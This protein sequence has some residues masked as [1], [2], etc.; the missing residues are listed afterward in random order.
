MNELAAFLR[1]PILPPKWRTTCGRSSLSRAWARREEGGYPFGSA[2]A[3]VLDAALAL[4]EKYGFATENHAYY[5]GSILYGDAEKELGIVTHLDVVPASKEG[6]TGDPFTLL[7]DGDLLIGRGTEDD[8][9]PFIASLYTLRFLKETRR[10]LPFAVRLILGCDEESGCTDLAHYL[11]VRSAPFF[12][13]TPDSEY[14]VCIGEKGMYGFDLVVPCD[15]GTEITGGSAPNA[16]PASRTRRPARLRGP[17][18]A[19]VR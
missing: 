18:R 10:A 3:A 5:C 7:R 4:G 8:K 19:A 11:S 12:A 16:V 2:C 15:A 1:R 9:G 6:W 13:F 17:G 14:P